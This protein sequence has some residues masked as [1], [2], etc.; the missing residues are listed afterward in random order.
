M[1][2]DESRSVAGIIAQSMEETMGI[3]R[4]GEGKNIRSTHSGTRSMI[5]FHLFNLLILVVLDNYL[6]II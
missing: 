5:R 1:Y 2:R 3:T 4:I 6:R